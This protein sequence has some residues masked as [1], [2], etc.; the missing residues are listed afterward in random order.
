VVQSSPELR[1][2]LAPKLT[3][4]IPH[5]PT[6]KQTAFLLL[7]CMDAFYGGAAGGGKSDALLMAALQYMDIPGYASLLLR[8]SVTNLTLPGALMDRAEEWLGPTDAI[9][10]DKQK[11]WKAPGGGTLSFGYLD[12]PRDHLRYKSAE[13]Q[14]I[15]IDEA[16]DLRWKQIM[17][18]FSRLRRLANVTIPVRF[19]LGSNPGG[20]SHTDLKRRYINPFTREERVFI[21]AG[22][23]DNPHL[24]R[25][26]YV[27][28]LMNL[29]P[30]S[31]EQLLKGDWEVRE[32]GRMFSRSWFK[33][34]DE[35]PATLAKTARY[36]D[37]AATEPKAGNKEPDWSSGC[38]MSADGEGRFYIHSIVRYRKEPRYNEAMVRQVADM[39]GRKVAIVMEQEPGSAGKGQI[40]HYR[41]KI[42]PEFI[43]KGDKVTGSKRQ[44]AMPLASQ[45]EAGNVYLINGAW[46]EDFLDEIEIFPDGN[47]DDQVDSSSGAF[48]IV[49]GSK[50]EPR[51]RYI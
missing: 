2:S 12:G 50:V 3:K 23:D 28:S 47:F 9:W 35:A 18:M 43:F 26:Q 51:A 37:L 31:R 20:I 30:V 38:K 49:G 17:Y 14:F 16:G 32:A 39:D 44:R 34:V 29:D 11:T 21:P 45:A 5:I 27:K 19:R 42:L 40:D 6:P 46:N 36:W 8:D 24:D 48:S 41:R 10:L 4:Y 22:L 13:F 25:E 7:T 33:I 1:N 15:G